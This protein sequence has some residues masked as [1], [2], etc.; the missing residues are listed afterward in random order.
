MEND[1][2]D[3]SIKLGRQL[4]DMRILGR[5]VGVRSTEQ[6]VWHL[7]PPNINFILTV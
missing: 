1:K 2:K 3:M 5:I 6:F 7:L 4:H